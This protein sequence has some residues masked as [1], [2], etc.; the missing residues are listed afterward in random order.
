MMLEGCKW[1]PQI[2][3]LATLAPF[4]LV[5]PRGV[6]R[7]LGALAERLAAE[8]LDAER[9]LLDHPECLRV[10]GMPRA[11][12]RCSPWRLSRLRPLPG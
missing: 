9:A 10:L 6:A 8:A 11:I 2:S 1:D 4:P 5:V 12:R 3:D 7:S